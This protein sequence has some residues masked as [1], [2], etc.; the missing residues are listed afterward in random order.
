MQYL[1][2]KTDEVPKKLLRNKKYKY[3]GKIKDL[4]YKLVI[5]YLSKR[6]R[7]I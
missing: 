7:K 1:F 2:C 4:M 5:S 6:K 3:N